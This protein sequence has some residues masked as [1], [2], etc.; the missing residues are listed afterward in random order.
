MIHAVTGPASLR[1]LAPHVSTSTLQ[2][3]LRYAWEAAAKINASWNFGGALAGA[4]EREI[5]REDVIDQAVATGDEHA[6]KL[7]EACLRE[8]ALNP[9][10]AYLAAAEDVVSRLR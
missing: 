4:E 2:R 8:H 10:P 6:M 5:D 3:V 7:V 9:R 1:L